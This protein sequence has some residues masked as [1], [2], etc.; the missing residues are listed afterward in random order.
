[1]NDRQT[2]L[3][4]DLVA[5]SW[6]LEK[7]LKARDAR[8]DELKQLV[9]RARGERDEVI[10]D[11]QKQERLHLTE[12]F[13]RLGDGD[14][15]QGVRDRGLDSGLPSGWSLTYDRELREEAQEVV[16]LTKLES[17]SERPYHSR[18][19]VDALASNPT[20]DNYTKERQQRL[21]LE[22]A[23]DQGY[24]EELR[25]R[26]RRIDFSSYFKGY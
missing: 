11:L 6:E 21:V 15:Y 12:Y 18:I 7:E 25:D 1:M 20:T 14:P 19:A 2:R 9:L 26:S 8:I 24:A 4:V 17:P 5:R 22:N 3:I 13:A 16:H 23:L 10:A